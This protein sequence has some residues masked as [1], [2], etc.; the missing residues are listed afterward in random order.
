MGNE[1][2]IVAERP[3]A[4]SVCC[5]HWIIE[6]A[7]GPVSRGVCK[8]CGEG[9]EFD[10]FLPDLWLREDMTTLLDFSELVDIKQDME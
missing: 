6:N 1:I 9:R 2:G 10:N 8:F 3:V 7:V 5:H 4:D